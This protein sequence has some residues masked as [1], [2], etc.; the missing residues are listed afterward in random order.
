MSAFCN[1][2][3]KIDEPV[4]QNGLAVTP[5][6]MADLAAHGVPITPQNLGLGYQ[7]GVSRLDYEPPLEYQRGIDMADLWDIR[8]NVKDKVRNAKKAAQQQKGD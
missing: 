1:C 2:K 4:V 8:Q 3:R 5:A 7:E 6:Q